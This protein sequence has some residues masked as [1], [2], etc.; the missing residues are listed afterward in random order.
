MIFQFTGQPGH[1]KSVLAI[2]LLLDFKA[3][4]RQ[5]YACNVKDFDYER[6]GVLPMTPDEFRGWPDNL[7]DGSVVLVD[8]CYQHEM[9]PKLGP[10]RP[11]PK[12]VQELAVHRHRGLD[13]IFVCQSPD[14]QMHNFIHD[15][16]EEHYHVRRRY[17]LPFVHVRRFDKFEAS[18]EKTTPLTIKR[19]KYPKHIFKLY[20]S[21]KLDTSA[22]RVPWFYYAAWG[23]GAFVLIFGGY[24]VYRVRSKFTEPLHPQSAALE[25][26]GKG[27]Q[28]SSPG[29][30]AFQ[31]QEIKWKDASEYSRDHLPRFGSMPW[32]APVY[33]QRSVTADPQ[34][35]CMSSLPGE[36]AQGQQQGLSCT[37]YT[38]QAT[39]YDLDEASCRLLAR[40]GARHNPYRAQ[41]SAAGQGGQV[42]AFMGNVEDVAVPGGG[43]VISGKLEH[44]GETSNVVKAPPTHF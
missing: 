8:E 13:F 1:G 14:K 28:V 29:D 38:E 22:Q 24:T 32:T 11:V 37:C 17:G 16:I 31:K 35:F 7:P 18:P 23:L 25:G 3:K 6:T 20:T 42:S 12:W 40:R 27:L 2:E 30:R 34:V 15:L 21:T 26:Q 10:S 9:L 33:D 19:R 41:S 44:V 39:L 43:S 4:G 5:C 36:D